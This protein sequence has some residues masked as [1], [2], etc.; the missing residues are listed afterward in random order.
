VIAM[1]NKYNHGFGH[2]VQQQVSSAVVDLG[3]INAIKTEKQ[4]TNNV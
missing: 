3:Y 1:K 2:E 4:E